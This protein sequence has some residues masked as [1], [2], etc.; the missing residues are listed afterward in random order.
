MPATDRICNIAK[1]VVMIWTCHDEGM[2]Y[3]GAVQ[4]VVVR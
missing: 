4:A 1:N 2:M 3:K